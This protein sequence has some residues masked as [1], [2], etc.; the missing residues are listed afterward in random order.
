MV[1][2]TGTL[3][4][5]WHGDHTLTS[6][7]IAEEWIR[8]TFSNNS[9]II[10]TI[11][12]MMMQ[13]REAIVNYMTPLG[14][15]HIMGWGH[16]YGPQPW[17]SEAERPD[18]NSIY[19][20]RADEK[21]LGFDRTKK[22]SNAIEQYFQP[23]QVHFENLDSC[24]ENMLLWFHHVNWDYKMKSGRTLWNELC[25]KYFTGVDSVRQMRKQWNNLEGKIDNEQFQNVKARLEIQEREATWWRDA[26]IQYFQTF[27]KMPIPQ[28]FEKPT[29]SLEELKKIKWKFIQGI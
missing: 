15:H 6:E 20:H 7:K 24:P 29:Q 4:A 19:Y 5:G 25:I 2:Q 13:S 21:G 26:C 23:I 1:K 10:N 18:W 12:P 28:G 17:L 22:G 14:L 27:S 9:E 8:M 16:H 3:L 11:L